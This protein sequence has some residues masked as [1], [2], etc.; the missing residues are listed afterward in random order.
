MTSAREVVRRLARSFE[1]RDAGVLGRDPLAFP[2]YADAL[3]EA[4]SASEVREACIWGWADIDGSRCALVAFDFS[5][6]GG[7]MG[8]AV[9]EKVA[10]AFDAARRAKLPVV[11][12]TASG[13]A[14]MQEGMVSLVQMAKTAEARRAH[15]GAGLPAVTLLCSPT[16]GGVY[17]SF[18]SLA[19][20]ILAEPE[21]TVGFAGPRVVEQMT[22]HAPA[23]HVHRAEFAFEHGLLDG[24]V[25]V[26]HQVPAIG[27]FLRNLTA[28]PAPA[29]EEAAHAVGA[30]PRL[31]G[32]TTLQIAR[33]PGRPKAAAI[34]SGLLHDAVELRGDR[35][36]GL[37]PAVV[38]R[39]GALRTTGRRV[40]A[41]GQ[42]ASGDGRIRPAGYRTAIRA[43]E[44]AG[45]LGLP[46][47]TLID[48]RGADP[49]PDAEAGGVAGAIARTFA[50]M[51]GCPSPTLAVV[52]GEGGSGGALAM[53]AADHVLAWEHAVFSVIAPE[54]AAAI[55]HRDASRA[56][57]LAEALR[58]TA[59][60]LV[61]LG[62]ADALIAEPAGGAHT[63]P[64]AAV[65]S[66]R[67]AVGQAMEAVAS[68]ARA[69]RLT[70]RRRRWR[71]AGSPRP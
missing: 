54:G 12:A 6:L 41:I 36:G 20:V 53:A 64:D 19:D 48:T 37:D 43:I 11:C 26:S 21:A 62:I 46:V 49:S 28:A 60:D 32:W 24:I 13:G 33:H 55:L 58:I 52:T 4:R 56:P 23:P 8:W 30:G 27:R 40:L 16:T 45:R 14:R 10:R 44:L 25:E 63:A 38:V 34:L 42:D 70:L 57:E 59:H 18:A 5:F 17:A 61:D 71:R 51:L 2:G 22:G 68:E 29:A 39:A 7:S 1:E 65:A 47:L 50:A 15:A 3:T 67:A 35:E 9:G 69:G 66:L 31:D